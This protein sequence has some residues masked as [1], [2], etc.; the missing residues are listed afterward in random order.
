MYVL[1]S[2]FSFE[3]FLVLKEE[4]PKRFPRTTVGFLFAATVIPNVS[5]RN[6]LVFPCVP[7]WCWHSTLWNPGYLARRGPQCCDIVPSV[8]LGTLYPWRLSSDL[9]FAKIWNALP[10]DSGAW[11]KGMTHPCLRYWKI[12]CLLALLELLMLKWRETQPHRSGVR[13]KS[14]EFELWLCAR[15]DRL[16]HYAH[17]HQSKT[18][19]HYPRAC[20]LVLLHQLPLHCRRRLAPALETS[21]H[22]VALTLGNRGSSLIHWDAW[23]VGHDEGTLEEVVPFLV[24]GASGF[25][26]EK[27]SL[28]RQGRE[29]REKNNQFQST[30]IR[31]IHWMRKTYLSNNSFF[32]QTDTHPYSAENCSVPSQTILHLTVRPRVPQPSMAN[33]STLSPPSPKWKNTVFH[34]AQQLIL[35]TKIEEDAPSRITWPLLCKGSIVLLLACQ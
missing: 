2:L 31:N 15:Y 13:R 7:W 22:A 11:E 28:H 19:G 25:C 17:G 30:V 21:K 24:L 9:A 12:D 33:H 10:R 18:H 29:G 32:F 20:S 26:I 23:N 27:C 4:V 3:V 34:H 14:S 1:R 16:S 8:V 5:L 35:C 6:P